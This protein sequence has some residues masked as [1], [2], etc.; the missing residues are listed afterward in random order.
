MVRGSESFQHMGTGTKSLTEH[1]HRY[2]GKGTGR[3]GVRELRTAQDVVNEGIQRLSGEGYMGIQQFFNEQNV[4]I[5]SV[6]ALAQTH[7]SVHGHSME[8]KGDWYHGFLHGIQIG[9]IAG[10]EGMKRERKNGST[11]QSN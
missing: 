4:D 7:M 11:G 2:I 1:R 10:R 3:V 6:T 5:T 8:D 9:I